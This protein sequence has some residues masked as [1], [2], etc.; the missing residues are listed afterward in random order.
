MTHTEKKKGNKRANV[1][2]GKREGPHSKT[3]HHRVSIHVSNLHVI[4]PP[5]GYA[6]LLVDSPSKL[7]FSAQVDHL[8]F[9]NGE[10]TSRV[11]KKDIALDID[12]HGAEKTFHLL[13][14]HV[15]H[16]T[17]KKDAINSHKSHRLIFS[18]RNEEGKRN[19]A[20]QYHTHSKAKTSKNYGDRLVAHAARLISNRD[21]PSTTT[22]PL[23][24]KIWQAEWDLDEYNFVKFRKQKAKD[25]LASEETIKQL[26]K[27]QVDEAL[28]NLKDR[29]TGKNTHQDPSDMDEKTFKRIITKILSEWYY[30]HIRKDA[31][32]VSPFDKKEASHREKAEYEKLL[33][34]WEAY[35]GENAESPQKM[36]EAY[37]VSKQ[38]KSEFA[39][40]LPKKNNQGKEEISTVPTMTRMN[41]QSPANRARDLT[42]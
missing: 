31:D 40:V 6:V 33:R 36:I 26:F 2:G 35:Y 9:K 37:V 42:F 19:K 16:V 10:A 32:G 29:K 22:V 24:E 15:L 1:R 17:L 5:K 4:V 13:E 34:L 25:A 38:C 12:H 7:K 27:N 20:P 28:K 30:P 21:H 14:R 18:L 23:P 8:S 41:R 3:D 39:F 11:V